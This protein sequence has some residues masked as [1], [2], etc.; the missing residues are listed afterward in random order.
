MADNGT[1]ES[2]AEV[3]VDDLKEAP[4]E[5][6]K[7][8]SENTPE[9]VTDDTGDEVAKWKS[10][11]R[12]NEQELSKAIKQLD[13][14]RKAEDERLDKQI[15][16]LSENLRE[17]VAAAVEK[18]LSKADALDLMKGLHTETP[19]EPA[20]EAKSIRPGGFDKKPKADFISAAEAARQ[21]RLNEI[22]RDL[23]KP[24]R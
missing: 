1:Q 3:V 2:E 7:S 24:T 12:K 15:E 19:S 5:E 9:E 17:R 8:K 16:G 21:E 22:R 18:G 10:M 4:T 14:Y 11:A 6:D 23:G 13:R 20:P